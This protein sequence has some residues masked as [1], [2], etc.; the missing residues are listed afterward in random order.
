M[1]DNCDVAAHDRRDG[2]AI[3]RN[4]R[5]TRRIA[6]L[7][8][9]EIDHSPAGLRTLARFYRERYVAEFPDPDER[10]SLAN[11]R[12]YLAL[13]AQGW[14]GA[15]NYHIVIA[16]FGGEA[17]GGV[18]FDYLAAADAGVIE[19][20]FVD[21]S[22]RVAG[23]GRAL[24]D[25]SVRILRADARER[26]GRPLKAV[27]AEMNDP[28]RRPP[29]PDNMDPFRR[30]TI[31]G[32]WGFQALGFPYVQPALSAGQKPVD[33]LLL[34]A[35]LFG[36]VP[37]TGVAAAWVDRVVTEYLRWAMRIDDPAADRD[38][39]AMADF[40]A[41]RR[42]IALHPLQHYIGHDPQRA[43]EVEEIAAGEGSD[44]FSATLALARAA[45]P[46][47]GRVASPAEFSAA[48]AAARTGGP[49]Y[50]LWALRTAAGRAIEGMASFFTLKSAGFGG[51]IVL[52]GA[53]RGRGL[54]MQLVAR[55][56]ARMLQDGTR[57]EGWFIEC[58]DESVAAFRRAGFV[59]IP[60]DY[61]PPR[62]GEQAPSA[63]ATPLPERLQLLYKPFGMACRPPR[64]A[65]TFILRALH[66]ILHDVYGIASPRRHACYRLARRT[67]TN[68]VASGK[69]G[70]V[71]SSGTPF[72]SRSL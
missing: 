30:A 59:E 42:R 39:L 14:Y 57:A 43:F 37:R 52:G 67:L 24:F 6:G 4:G 72:A 12:R 66:E 51:Y 21:A 9:R 29:T 32:K 28:Y 55:I 38:Y 60:L 41:A 31:W 3:D 20:L 23:L 26:R 64:P 69:A 53:L 46:F 70:S 49:A 50:H 13:K 17:V 1:A 8:L 5:A 2:Q 10:E 15:N 19:F 7:R 58:G 16:E 71:L 33:C 65:D 56:E 22:H 48:Q 45:I 18:V 40:L 11:M 68:A 62:V 25:E 47:P 36:R 54:L 35:R 34:I 27:V 63:A 61:R 44:V